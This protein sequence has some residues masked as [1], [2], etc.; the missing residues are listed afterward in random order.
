MA[1]RR[2]GES[3][4]DYKIRQAAYSKVYRSE[5]KEER[6]SK[7]KVYEA[8]HREEK[9]AS[10][11]ANKLYL[12]ML[13]GGRCAACHHNRNTAALEFHHI[14][15][16]TKGRRKSRMTIE[17]AEKCILL[18]ANCPREYHFGGLQYLDQ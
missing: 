17:E 14:D 1:A 12:I 11:A 2:K 8:I 4:E 13:H 6:L 18:C 15:P 16:K 3:K 9:L 7:K 10:Y 5:H